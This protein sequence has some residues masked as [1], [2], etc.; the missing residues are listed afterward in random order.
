M[1]VLF[2]VG[3]AI[4]FPAW[5][6]LDRLGAAVVSVIILQASVKIIWTGL[7]EF[8]DTGASLA[9]RQQIRGI[10]SENSGVIQVHNIRTRYVATNL[11][12]DM[13]VVVDGSITV[14]EGHDIAQDIEERLLT[15]GLG[16]ERVAVAF[17]PD[18]KQ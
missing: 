9:T 10:A 16:V 15:S 8:M 12:V 4:L 7:R 18:Q 1:P 5:T 6:F 3:G 2:A 11:H 17:A 14:V 13:H